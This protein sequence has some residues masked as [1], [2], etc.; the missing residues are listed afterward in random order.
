MLEGNKFPFFGLSGLDEFGS[1]LGVHHV[2]RAQVSDAEEQAELPVALGDDAALAEDERL[3]ALLRPRDLHE[4]AA[5]H[6]RVDDGA[7][8]GLRHDQQHALPAVRRHLE[9]KFEL[10]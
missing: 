4:H 7:Q 3:R 6:E 9:D 2:A 1:D 10:A 5:H 8:D